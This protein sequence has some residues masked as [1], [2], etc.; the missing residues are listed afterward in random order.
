MDSE[1][2]AFEC[3]RI[4][5]ENQAIDIKIFDVRK[6]TIIADF[7][8]IA[9][10]NSQIHIKALTDK[11]QEYLKDNEIKS[12]H[13]EGMKALK[14]ILIDTFSVIVHIFLP[15]TRE[16]YNLEGYWGDSEIY[17]MED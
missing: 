16:Y 11:I 5:L 17:V 8:I 13:L 1:Q 6:L 10:A 2:L 14:W 7:F 3:G 4:L 9:S 12:F 15:E